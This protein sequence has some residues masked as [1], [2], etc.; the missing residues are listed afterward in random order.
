[1]A[2]NDLGFSQVGTH[3]AVY[4]PPPTIDVLTDLDPDCRFDSD[5]SSS[6]EQEMRSPVENDSQLNTTVNM[7]ESMSIFDNII[8]PKEEPNKMIDP[9]HI[10]T[11][12]VALK[13]RHH[14]SNKCIEDILA[15]LQLLKVKVPSSYKA[16][17]TLL[18][19]R[20]STHLM[21]TKTTI[22]PHCQMLSSAM[23]KCTACDAPYAPILSSAI[24]L[25]YTYDI[26]RQLEAVLATSED[27]VIQIS[28]ASTKKIMRD[29][30]DGNVYKNLLEKESGPFITLTMNVDGVQPNKG[31]DQSLWPALFVV[32]EI[33]RK[34]RYSPENVIIGGMWPGPSKPS[35]AQM[36]L[37][38]KNIVLEL[39]NLEKG[40]LFQLYSAEQDDHFDFIKVFLIASCCDKPA[41]C[42][43]HVN[44][45]AG[46]DLGIRTDKD[47][48]ED[49]GIDGN[50]GG[51]VGIGEAVDE[52]VCVGLDEDVGVSVPT[53]KGGS[54]VSFAI[55]ENNRACE[56]SNERH[57]ILLQQ[58]QQSAIKIA[59]LNGPRGRR[60][61]MQVHKQIQKR[62]KGVCILRTLSYYDV[63]KSFLVDSLHNIY[64]GLCKRLLS[65]WL[66]HQNKDE[67]W[68]VW[69]RTNELSTLLVRFRFPSTTTR[70]PRSLH[71]FAKYKG[72]LLTRS[73]KST[74][75]HA[76]EIMNN[77]I[78]LR[79]AHFELKNNSMCMNLRELIS[80]WLHI[81][82]SSSTSLTNPVRTLH[83]IKITDK[84]LSSIFRGAIVYYSTAFIGQ[85][86]L[87]T[88]HYAKNKVTDDS[89]IIFKIGSKEIFGR[90]HRIFT[91]NDAEPIF[92]INVLSNTTDFKCKTITDTYKYSHIRTGSF[93][94]Q[95]S[96]VFISANDFV[97]KCVFYERKNKICT[98]YRYPNLEECS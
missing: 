84:F 80:S 68:S 5:T 66:N 85:V 88:T 40:Q 28:D 24:P 65:L 79:D 72:R 90:I 25:F 58:L 52:D 53:R 95:T 87:T 1:M 6:L 12:L 26:T 67:D 71:K 44:D 23:D 55:Y 13:A 38:F 81:R 30:T 33:K 94:D 78:Y 73:C 77:L 51:D 60:A 14:L 64:L 69:C 10:A 18:R 92:Y 56:R 39:Q 86:R 29:I 63:G 16:L 11:A 48:G 54:V 82:C 61:L 70:H 49:A 37:F 8:M 62:F 41:Q 75:R 50:I 74:R 98:F 19:K 3:E 59:A 22:C 42:L 47:V 15:L 4:P 2:N 32:N 57:D 7:H 34:K 91:V 36:S 43:V 89:S 46:E 45:Y 31:S 9:I 96:G 35:R 83:S 97:E 21:P 27:L 17:C 20:S 93:D 76:I